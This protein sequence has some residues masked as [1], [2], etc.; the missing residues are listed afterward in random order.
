MKRYL[1]ISSTFYVH[2][3]YGNLIKVVVKRNKIKYRMSIF[4]KTAYFLCP[5]S[6][7]A[8]EHFTI[9]Q[10]Q[11]SNV[12]SSLRVKQRTLWWISNT[13]VFIYEKK[14]SLWNVTLTFPICYFKKT[15]RA[16][17]EVFCLNR[18]I[19]AVAF[20]RRI[21][22]CCLDSAYVYFSVKQG[23]DY[24]SNMSLVMFLIRFHPS[25]SRMF[26]NVHNNKS[27][28]ECMKYYLLKTF[29]KQTQTDLH[30]NAETLG[31]QICKSWKE[32]KTQVRVQYHK[33]LN[34]PS[35]SQNK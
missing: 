1:R 30:C 5:D 18:H 8:W 22:P 3:G 7:Y 15:H 11:S 6:V 4:H 2:Y 16:D 23:L 26:L 24:S 35:I 17:Q 25:K 31:M 33:W 28:R 9:P 19:F 10:A 32:R 34:G 20:K 27:W 21:F 29:K 12:C 13:W 14:I